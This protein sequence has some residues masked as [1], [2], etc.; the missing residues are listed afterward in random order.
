MTEYRSQ[1][2]LDWFELPGIY[3][4]T[5]LSWNRW[6]GLGEDI[7]FLLIGV[8]MFEKAAEHQSIAT[9]QCYNVTFLKSG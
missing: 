2:Y 5:E 7:S 4:R 8:L 1:Q 3:H 9:T 6:G